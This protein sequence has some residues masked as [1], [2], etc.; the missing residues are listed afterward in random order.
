V[1]VRDGVALITAVMKTRSNDG[2]CDALCASVTQTIT[3]DEPL[4]E[5]VRFEAPPEPDPGC[6]EPLPPPH[7]ASTTHIATTAGLE[8][9]ER[10]HAD[11]A[12]VRLASSDAL[13]RCCGQTHPCRSGFV[14]RGLRVTF[15]AR[16]VAD[17][18]H[19]HDVAA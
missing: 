7:I 12:R 19:G 14:A 1:D 15:G 3:L 2:D 13:R 5:G 17:R 9:S 11:S 10:D 4:P 6:R 18:A 8:A 16:E